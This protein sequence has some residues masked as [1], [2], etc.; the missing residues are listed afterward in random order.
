MVLD[1]FFGRGDTVGVERVHDSAGT[2]EA[3]T[4]SNIARGGEPGIDGSGVEV[5]ADIGRLCDVAVEGGCGW[6]CLG[7]G[8]WRRD[9]T[10]GRCGGG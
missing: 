6:G 9:G 3:D 5:E 1:N 10:A 7:L 8:I 2:S 4:N